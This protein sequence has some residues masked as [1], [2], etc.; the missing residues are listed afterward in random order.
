M[1]ADPYQVLGVSPSASKEEITKAYKQLA[2]KYHPDLNPGN[3]EAA[4]KMSEINAAYEAIKSGNPYGDQAGSSYGGGSYGGYGGSSYGGGSYGGY[5]GSYNN[6]QSFIPVQNYINSGRFDEALN[7]LN[8]MRERPAEWYYFSALAH[9]GKG[10]T[11]TALNYAQQ[12]ANMDPANIQY[13]FLIMRLQNG[14][15]QYQQES[16]SYGMPM[17]CGRWCLYCIALNCFCNMCCPH[18]YCTNG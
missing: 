4:R 3:A 6:S 2:K 8:N 15:Q 17:D 16:E 18:F 7:M 10:N 9:E 11:M 1:N 14:G 13:R 12:A 5:S